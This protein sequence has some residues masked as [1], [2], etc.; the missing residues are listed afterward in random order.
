MLESVVLQNN[1]CIHRCLVYDDGL[2]LNRSQIQNYLQFILQTILCHLWLFRVPIG[3]CVS[4]FF[5]C[6]CVCLGLYTCVQAG[7][8][9]R[10]LGAGGCVWRGCLGAVV[11]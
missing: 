4:V 2:R 8:G 7:E 6:V 9:K 10:A 11:L 5:V 3:V 1:V